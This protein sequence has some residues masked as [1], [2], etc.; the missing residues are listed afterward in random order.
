MSGSRLF[1]TVT[2]ARKSRNARLD[3]EFETR[4][5]RR[6]GAVSASCLEVG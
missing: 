4:A 5:A 6:M 3:M 1:E 2:T